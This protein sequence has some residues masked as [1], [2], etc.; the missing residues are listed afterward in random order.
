MPSHRPGW[1]EPGRGADGFQ[2]PLVLCSCFQ[3]RLTPGI[4]RQEAYRRSYMENAMAGFT[5]PNGL[6]SHEISTNSV[7]IPTRVGGAGPAVVLLHGYGE[8]GDMWV[9]LAGNL[10]RDHTVIVPDL[11]GLGRSSKPPSGFDKRTQAGD[12]AGMLA[13]LRIGGGGLGP[14]DTGHMGGGALSP[15]PPPR[16]RRFLLVAAPLPGGRPGGEEPQ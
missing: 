16:G 12:V 10:V 13:A 6:T 9:P 2:R 7:T 5:V 1:A 4:G 14:H 15:P 11:R 3:R 8:T